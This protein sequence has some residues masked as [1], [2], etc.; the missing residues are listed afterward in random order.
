M[1]LLHFYILHLLVALAGHLGGSYGLCRVFFIAE[2]SFLS[3][4][5]QKQQARTSRT[6]REDVYVRESEIE[7]QDRVRIE[8][9]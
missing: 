9:E 5:E 4:Q 1:L 3:Q 2:F 6:E 8:I 7:R